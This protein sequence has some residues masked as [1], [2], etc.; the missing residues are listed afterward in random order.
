MNLRHWDAIEPY[1]GRDGALI[2]ELASPDD[3]PPTRHSLAEIRHPPATASREH[4]HTR[5]EEGYYVVGGSSVIRIDDETRKPKHGDVVVIVPGQSHRIWPAI[6]EDLVL[7]VT[8]APAIRR[9]KWSLSVRLPSANRWRGNAKPQP[10][11]D[12]ERLRFPDVRH[13]SRVDATWLRGWG[14]PE[15]SFPQPGHLSQMPLIRPRWQRLGT[16]AR[17]QPLHGLIHH[18]EDAVLFET[19]GPS[20]EIDDPG[21]YRRAA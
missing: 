17:E 19:T 14:K 1:T 18:T 7:L 6:K 11:V 13:P 2:R 10:D 9:T 8:C 5:E 3:S 12:S 21:R 16:G 20:Q 15:A 4:H